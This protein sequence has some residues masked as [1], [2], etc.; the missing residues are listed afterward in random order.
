MRAQ[1]SSYS[2]PACALTHSES[3]LG[4][5][6]VP[7]ASLY[8]DLPQTILMVTE[9]KMKKTKE[10][11]NRSEGSKSASCLEKIIGEEECSIEKDGISK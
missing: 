7:V 11:P 2:S 6:M 8:G 10:H 1:Y 4:T 9:K 5:D 3:S